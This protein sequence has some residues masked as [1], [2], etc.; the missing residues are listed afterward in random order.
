MLRDAAK[1]PLIEINPGAIDRVDTRPLAR[2][3]PCDSFVPFAR[4]GATQACASPASQRSTD[5]RAAR[6]AGAARVAA[7]AVRHRLRRAGAASRCV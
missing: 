6:D 1:R 3:V 5:A 2:L 7:V 4:R